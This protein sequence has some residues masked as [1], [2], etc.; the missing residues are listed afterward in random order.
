LWLLF[1]LSGVI[2]LVILAVFFAYF[3]APLVRF[4]EQPWSIRGRQRA[5]PRA[6]AIGLVYLLLVCFAGA[7]GSFVIP[8]LGIEIALLAEQAP[9]YVAMLEAH[10]QS[11]SQTIQDYDLPPQA[12][13]AI[14]ASVSSALA[15]AGGYVQET[16]LHLLGSITYI[17]WLVLVPVLG[18]FFLKDGDALRQWVVFVLPR[19]PWRQGA[20]RFLGDIDRTIASFIRAQ[21][22]ACLLVGTI[23]TAGFSIIGVPFALVLGV[24]AGVF[25]FIPL[26]GPLAIAVIAGVFSGL[27]SLHTA[28]VVLVFLGVL[29]VAQDYVFYPRIL[30]QGGHLHPLAVI[31]AVLCG[32]EIAGIAGIFL[33]VPVAGIIAVVVRQ[34]G[35]TEEIVADLLEPGPAPAARIVPDAAVDPAAPAGEQP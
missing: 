7:I 20:A 4:V 9:A 17:P 35:G 24:L 2:L 29:R 3:I 13:A 30:G 26:I 34:F 27:S 6:V 8:R 11:L 5:L 25:E 32:A 31:L 19:G 28:F 18:F 23:C 16:A 1:T 21:L 12:E 15:S 33:S 10:V 22:I 14:H